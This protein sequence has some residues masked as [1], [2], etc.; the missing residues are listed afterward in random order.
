MIIKPTNI[1]KIADGT[2]K[3]IKVR[4]F[5]IVTVSKNLLT[6]SG[7]YTSERCF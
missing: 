7:A 2:S 6:N 1:C 4:D 5:C 3:S